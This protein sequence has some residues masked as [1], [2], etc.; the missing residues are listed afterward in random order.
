MRDGNVSR[1]ERRRASAS[2]EEDDLEDASASA[3]KGSGRGDER[4][5]T[6]RSK[7][8][9][10]SS[11][12]DDETPTT[13]RAREFFANKYWA[14][15][16]SRYELQEVIGKGSYGTVCAALDR[17]TGRRVAIKKVKNAFEHASD[18]TRILREVA[19]LR[20]LKHPDIVEV[21]NILLPPNPRDFNDVFI[22]FELMETDLHHVIKA[23]DDLTDEHHQFFLYQLLRGLKYMHS[24]NVFH[25]DL[26]PKNILANSDCKLKI[27]DF[28]LARPAFAKQGPQMIFWTDYVATRWY[29]A[30]ELCGSFFTQYTPAIDIWGVGCIFAELLRGAPLFPGKNVV[31]Q[32][33]M[34]TD[35]L[36]TP[37]PLQIAKVRNEKARKFLQNM[38][39]KPAVPLS[40]KFP[41]VAPKAL[42]LLSKLLAFDPDDRPTAAQALADPYFEGMADIT[43]EPSRRPLSKEMFE[44]DSRKLTREEVRE[45]LYEEILHYHPEA[46]RQRSGADQKSHYEYPS[47]VEA[48]SE[49]FSS[50][51][52]GGA[53]AAAT[54]R[55]SRSLP[56]HALEGYREEL[57]MYSGGRESLGRSESVKPG[58]GDRPAYLEEN[59]PAVSME[60][61]LADVVQAM[62]LDADDAAALA[63]EAKALMESGHELII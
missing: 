13:S 7:S 43:R 58:L 53:S 24:A 30:P 41:K 23:N 18:A 31:N 48:M 37:T 10:S 63:K 52:Q 3:R 56:K 55:N 9:R 17:E 19:L 51:E 45:L 28:G 14:S 32:L 46:K 25:R 54:F 15:E 60:D 33:E 39:I 40:E 34:I 61:D 11:S 8:P 26:K 22:V 57:S 16:G 12:E 44:W 2:E 29:R 42:N 1:D 4:A 49:Q 47:G 20:T 35:T 50:M 36:G 38:R 27:C 59:A 62:S 6:T 21:L 5:R